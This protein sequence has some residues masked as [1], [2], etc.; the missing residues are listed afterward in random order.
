M[1]CKKRNGATPITSLHRVSLPPCQVRRH[2]HPRANAIHCLSPQ[3][4]HGDNYLYLLCLQFSP[5]ELQVVAGVQLVKSRVRRA[6]RNTWLRIVS[7]STAE[8]IAE[9]RDT[10]HTLQPTKPQWLAV[11]LYSRPHFSATEA[12]LEVSARPSRPQQAK[13]E[14]TEGYDMPEP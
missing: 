1:Q 8:K 2:R 3:D 14:T 5:N 7:P 13:E 10:D 12:L 4:L 11:S 9:V 6:A